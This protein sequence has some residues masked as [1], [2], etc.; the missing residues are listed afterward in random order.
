M[1]P[2]EVNIKM[3]KK[4]GNRLAK[5]ECFRR[6]TEKRAKIMAAV[7]IGRELALC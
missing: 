2:V 4:R 5:A 1:W 6:N 3:H 7:K